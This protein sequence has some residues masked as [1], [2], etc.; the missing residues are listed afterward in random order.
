[1]ACVTCPEPF[2]PEYQKLCAVTNQPVDQPAYTER[3]NENETVA[4]EAD[5][6]TNGVDNADSF[7]GISHK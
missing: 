3:P 7:E 5:L 6:D 1:M 4:N 2:T